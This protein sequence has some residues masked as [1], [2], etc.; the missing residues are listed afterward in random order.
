MKT[1]HK[2]KNIYK[3]NM[4]DKSCLIEGKFSLK[5]FE[6]LKDTQW[7][8][9][10]K[11]DGTN[12]RVMFNNSEIKFG[13]KTDNAQIP[14]KLYDKLN[15]IFIPQLDKFKEKFEDCENVC[16]YGEGYGGKIQAGK[17]YSKQENFVLFD[18][19]IGGWW[20]ERDSVEEIA[21]YFGLDIV[22]IVGE[23]TLSEA[24]ELVKTGFNSQW[25]EFEAEGVVV[26]PTI[27][28]HARNGERMIIKIKCKDF[29]NLKK[30]TETDIDKK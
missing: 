3:R 9:T 7:Y 2:I 20:L 14:V 11:V 19:K 10:E 29:K 1:Y 17:K 22:P 8:F 24:V 27:S 25:G 16:F 15:E 21:E 30:A 4:E 12:I 28:L 5:E 18:V 26:K 6:Y 23:G 13:G